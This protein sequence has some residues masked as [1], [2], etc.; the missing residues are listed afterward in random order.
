M[1]GL[2]ATA[3]TR[4]DFTAPLS[5]LAF[6][7]QDL[8]FAVYSAGGPTS[9]FSGDLWRSATPVG[10]PSTAVRSSATSAA[11]LCLPPALQPRQVLL[12]RQLRLPRKAAEAAQSKLF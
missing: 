3:L 4:T 1:A 8:Q 5:R 12:R 7:L 6:F 9:T 2:K 10:L 11:Q